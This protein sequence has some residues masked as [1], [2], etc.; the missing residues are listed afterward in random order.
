MA[1]AVTITKITTAITPT[2]QIKGGVT[3]ALRGR[4]L[5]YMVGLDIF[6]AV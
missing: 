3:A 5:L 6:V 4:I 2:E 1:N